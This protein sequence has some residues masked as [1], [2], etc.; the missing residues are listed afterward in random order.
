MIDCAN[1]T[2]VCRPRMHAVPGKW[3]DTLTRV[4]II[5]RIA[6]GRPR[7]EKSSFS[8]LIERTKFDDVVILEP[9]RFGDARGFFAETCNKAQL[10]KQ[11]LSLEFVQDNHSLSTVTGTLRGL[12]FQ[13]PPHA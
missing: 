9:K 12:H 8:V 1:H 7:A 4:T 10:A 5:Y 11:G 3:A 6:R 2:F 13:A